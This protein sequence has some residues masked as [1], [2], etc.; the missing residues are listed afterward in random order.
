MPLTVLL[1][2]APPGGF[3][4][5]PIKLLAILIVLGVWTKLLTWAD[6]DAPIAHLPREGINTGMIAGLVLAYAL[7]F[8][9]PN[10]AIAFLAL[11]LIFLVEVG[12]YLGMRHQKVGLADLKG[13]IKN[14]GK[15]LQKGDKTVQE[16]AGEV[17]FVNKSGNLVAAP[18]AETPEAAVYTTV[19]TLLA[20]PL[21]KGAELIEVAPAEGA[22]ATRYTVDGFGYRGATVDHNAGGDA[23]TYI[24]KMAGM[25]VADKRKP[26]SGTM[27]LMCAGKRLEVRIDTR[28][29]TA[30]ETMVINVEPKKRHDLKLDQLG[31]SETQLELLKDTI[32]GNAGI[33]LVSSPKGM[34]LTSMLYAI[35]RSHD[36]FLTHI[37]TI[38]RDAAADLEGITQNKLPPAATGAEEAKQLS[39]VIDQEPDTIML[40][41]LHD[42]KSAQQLVKFARKGKRVY[43]GLR[44]G[45]TQEA[46]SQ[47][48]KL[49]GD[50]ELALEQLVLVI[51]G[52]VLRLLCNACKVGY[53]PDPMTLRKLNMDPDRVSKLYQART[54]VMKDPKGNP[55]LCEFCNELHFKGRTGVFEFFV[56]DEDAKAAVHAGASPTQLKMA[57]R[58]QR[59]KYLQ[60]QALALVEKGDTS[61]QEVLRVLKADSD[62][63]KP[64]PPPPAAPRTKAPAPK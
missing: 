46:L 51:S 32:A 53:S 50:D 44:A 42:P 35:L 36:A 5:N 27:K 10:F 61:V 7:F 55:I 34:G 40:P 37:H 18:N 26:Q 28:G 20:D 38:E 23:I 6:K 3:Y 11:V 9:L 39:W 19:Q 33:V 64:P 41:S 2:A 12:V 13:E 59:A 31:F 22:M 8:F 49:V 47:W 21:K 29:S 4:D 58:K 48:R 54:T 56:I 60:E 45:S 16:V 25:D 43:V 1:T 17:Q 57:F 62:S 52:R 14:I 15:G 24:K 30:G 63:P